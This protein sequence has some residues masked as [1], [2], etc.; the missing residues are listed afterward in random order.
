MYGPRQW[1]VSHHAMHV[2]KPRV[3]RWG[4]GGPLGAGGTLGPLLALP[5]CCQVLLG[6]VCPRG[7]GAEV[8]CGS[9][10]EG[11]GR[12]GSHLCG[13][14]LGPLRSGSSSAPL[15]AR[16]PFPSCYSCQRPQSSA[17]WVPLPS[18]PRLRAPDTEIQIPNVCLTLPP[19]HFPKHFSLSLL[20]RDLSR[21]SPSSAW[22][23]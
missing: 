1:P 20:F 4:P 9:H 3:G 2:P 18:G 16:P 21:D 8:S 10:G 12:A 11:R 13:E 5:T 17:G 22:E 14:D 6:S 19:P 23:Q 7:A 15:P